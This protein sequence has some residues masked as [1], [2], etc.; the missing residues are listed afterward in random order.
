MALGPSG[1]VPGHTEAARGTKGATLGA[2]TASQPSIMVQKMTWDDDPEAFLYAFEWTATAAGWPE[3]QWAVVLIPCLIGLAQQAV[4]TLATADLRN[5]RKV[6]DTILQTLNL[7]PEAYRRKLHKIEFGPDYHPRL[8]GQWIRAACLRS[9]VSDASGQVSRG[10]PLQHMSI[11][12]DPFEHVST[13][14]MGPLV[15]A[16]SR[17]KYIL[18]LVDY[19]TWY[20][21]AGPLKSMKA[22]AVAKELA[23]I[24]ARTGFTKCH[25]RSR[26]YLHGRDYASP[27]AVHRGAAL[28]PAGYH[29]QNNGLVERFNGTL[30][31]I[32]R[33]FVDE[34][35]WNWLK[36][37]PFLLLLYRKYLTPRWATP[38][39]KFC[40][41]AT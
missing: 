41:S 4:D 11:V 15:L 19:A 32:L 6:R 5:Y 34:N 22:K 14:L 29:P 3:A 26:S 13:Y 23:H 17:H 39:S 38:R 18:I 33:K 1:P 12:T 21:E 31:R 27:V 7:S 8:I 16:A 30:K 35:G 9:R 28:T 37:L 36:W 25:N 40:M 10:G 24:F 20:P 2:V